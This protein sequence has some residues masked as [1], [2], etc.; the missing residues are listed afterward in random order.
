[1][2]YLL[3][4]CITF[5]FPKLVIFIFIYSNCLS[6][7]ISVIMSSNNPIIALLANEK[8]NGDNVVKWKSNINI[9]LLFEN[10]K[11]IL[12]EE[13]PPEPHAIASRTV[14]ERYDSWIHSNNKARYY[15]LASMND[16]LREKHEDM[17]T[18]YEIWE[19]LQD[20]FGKQFDQF[21]HEATCSYMNPKMKKGVSVREHVLNMIKLIHK[22][23]I[24]GATIDES[25][26]VSII[27]ESLTPDFSQ[28]TTN[29]VMN[30]LQ[31]N[32]TQLLNEL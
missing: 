5:I 23:E 8:L 29:Y 24:H 13:C 30:K 4:S 17:E 19:S 10:Q 7:L 16:V 3:H 18:A 26:Q 1:M 11:F 20:M 9:V 14:K 21:R 31:Y 32:M 2:F 15:M 27:L 12:T 22:A 25:T 6:Y 28:F